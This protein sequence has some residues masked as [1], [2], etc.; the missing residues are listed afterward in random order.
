MSDQEGYVLMVED[1]AD[2]VTLTL[3]SFEKNK[4]PYKIEVAR[5]GAEA[6]EHLLAADEQG[7]PRHRPPALI[8]LDIKLPKILGLEVL[9]RLRADPSLKNVPVIILT[10]SNEEKDRTESQRLG[11]DLYIRKPINFNDFDAVAQQIKDFLSAHS[12]T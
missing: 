10:S 11:A 6:L 4:F 2:D 5:D 8:L 1:N 9:K 12:P 7:K 3:R